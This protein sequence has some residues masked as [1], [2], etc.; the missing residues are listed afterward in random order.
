MRLNARM[1]GRMNEQIMNE[2][3]NQLT[4]GRM[5]KL[6]RVFGAF[7]GDFRD[8]RKHVTYGPT[9]GRTGRATDGQILLLRC[10]AASENSEKKEREREDSIEPL[11]IIFFT[12][13]NHFFV[14]FSFRN[15]TYLKS[16]TGSL[17]V[18]RICVMQ[19]PS[20]SN[21]L[22]WNLC[23]QLTYKSTILLPLSLTQ[24]STFTNWRVML[25]PCLAELL[26]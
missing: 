2:W 14:P 25:L 9:H 15:P 4:N 6:S 21:L 20:S 3:R 23:S 26:L 24:W 22:L 17:P 13:H 10:E 19:Q 8:K 1:N 5:N 18:L 11:L 7:L 12:I 16:A